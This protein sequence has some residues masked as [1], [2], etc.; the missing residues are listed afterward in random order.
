MI[1]LTVCYVLGLFNEEGVAMTWKKIGVRLLHTRLDIMQWQ[2]GGAARSNE[3]M[4]FTT[5]KQFDRLSLCHIDPHRKTHCSISL[6]KTS[7]H[8]IQSNTL[9]LQHISLTSLLKIKNRILVCK[10]FARDQDGREK[11][12]T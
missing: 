10:S 8:V 1:Q 6:D 5:Q 7:S 12:V 11:G 9:K 2:Q 4:T 3:M